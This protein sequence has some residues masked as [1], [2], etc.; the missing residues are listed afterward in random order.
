MDMGVDLAH[1]YDSISLF[2]VARVSPISR[3]MLEKIEILKKVKMTLLHKMR[4]SR[5]TMQF[6]TKNS[7]IGSLRN[8]QGNC[9]SNQNGK[10]SIRS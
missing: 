8:V 6:F 9:S 7:C 5:K 1:E 2:E 10:I 3:F 4:N